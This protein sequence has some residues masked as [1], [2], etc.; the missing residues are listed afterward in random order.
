VAEKAMARAMLGCSSSASTAAS[1][2]MRV[3]ASLS[4][5][6]LSAWCR[7]FTATGASLAVVSWA[8]HTAPKAPRPS[9]RSSTKR[10]PMREPTCSSSSNIRWR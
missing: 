1:R 4:P 2:A 7:I 6:L 9:G 5:P 10:P 3:S 8:S